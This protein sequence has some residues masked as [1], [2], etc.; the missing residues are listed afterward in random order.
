MK[1]RQYA[2]FK[3]NDLYDLA[4]LESKSEKYYSLQS[5][6]LKLVI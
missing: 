3:S 2:Y 1:G 6:K 4:R 5:T